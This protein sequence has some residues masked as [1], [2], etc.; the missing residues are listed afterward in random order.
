MMNRLILATVLIGGMIGLSS[1]H[2]AIALDKNGA[3][4]IAAKPTKMSPTNLSE[5]E[6]TQLGGKL[7]SESSG[8]CNSGRLCT[9]TDEN[10]KKHVVC[11]SKM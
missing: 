4:P 3:A 11:I 7:T 2:S 9:T 8:I 1:N 5:S 6:C 10:N